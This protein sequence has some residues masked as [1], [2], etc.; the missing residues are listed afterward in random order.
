MTAGGAPAEFV[1]KYNGSTWES[2][3]AGFNGIVTSLIYVNNA[4]YAGGYF[5]HSGAAYID[6]F[7]RWDG[8][9]WSE[10]S[11]GTNGPVLTLAAI[12][13]IIFV[14]GD[15]TKVQGYILGAGGIASYDT[16]KSIWTPVGAGVNGKVSDILIYHTGT[17]PLIRHIVVGGEFGK[18]EDTLA[19][20]IVE[21]YSNAWHP[22]SE[23]SAIRNKG[24][25][26]MVNTL[27]RDSQGN[28]YAGTCY[29]DY[30]TMYTGGVVKW[31]G[32]QWLHLG[33]GMLT[34]DG[35]INTLAFG[36]DD[37]L[38]AGGFFSPEAGSSYGAVGKWDGTE[39]TVLGDHFD[40]QVMSLAVS[41]AGVLYAGGIFSQYKGVDYGHVAKWNGTDWVK[42]GS[43]VTGGTVSKVAVSPVTDNLYVTGLF[44][45]AGGN[46]ANYI[47]RYDG[48]WHAL[49]SGTNE[50]I[51]DIVID[52]QDRLYAVGSFTMAGGVP[53]NRVAYWNG[54]WH[55]MGSG[56][57]ANLYSVGL[58]WAGRVYIGGKFT[59]V[60]GVAVNNVARWNGTA[61]SALGS[62]LTTHIT[63][64]N[65][66]V[67]SILGDGREGVYFG[68][69]FYQAG[70][71]V[72]NNMAYWNDT[73]KVFLPAVVR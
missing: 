25:P 22:L 6:Y 61:W 13:N 36:P 18:A 62:G 71:K 57:D 28:I 24:I 20:N 73:R 37:V 7:A 29:N 27:A 67:Y 39:W 52:K 43:G 59:N 66:V 16:D 1:A 64:G 9:S 41:Q 48:T 21:M 47:A 40:S 56:A 58:D 34:D 15:F 69:F 5:E 51:S 32:S 35:C 53:A 2:I 72:S 14:G 4:L 26:Q 50:R 10:V 12:G 60:G 63:D 3:G 17:L 49:S 30:A 44:T 70:D 45:A 68:G 55:S 42:L 31:N 19:A 11:G 33:G 46:P 65:R 38:Y 54:S 8:S 23:D